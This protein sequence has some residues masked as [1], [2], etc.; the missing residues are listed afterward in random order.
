MLQIM[1]GPDALC[2][3]E[4]DVKDNLPI[5]KPSETP[6]YQ[7]KP[8]INGN[9]AQMFMPS[10]TKKKKV[11]MMSLAS[12]GIPIAGQDNTR[13]KKSVGPDGKEETEDPDDDN[14]CGIGFR[15]M[16]SAADVYKCGLALALSLTRDS[17]TWKSL[18]NAAWTKTFFT[19]QF[20]IMAYGTYSD[21]LCHQADT[22]LC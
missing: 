6:E 18:A 9:A 5:K 19:S 10:K 11:T 20:T 12:L 13:I 17:T 15:K 22:R 14:G 3:D 1:I 2:T 8:S 7:S 16:K 21:T 4:P